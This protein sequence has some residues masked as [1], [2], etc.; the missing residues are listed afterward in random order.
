MKSNFEFKFGTIGESGVGKTSILR[1]LTEGRAALITESTLGVEHF[2]HAVQIENRLV[3]L[4]IWDTAGQ[5]RYGSIVK[6]YLRD[7]LGI[8]LVFDITDRSSF[9]LLPARYRSIA[10]EAAPN[11]SAVLVGNKTD[12]ADVRV[13]SQ[14]EAETFAKEHQIKYIETS[15]RNGEQ[16]QELFLQLTL[17]LLHKA[18]QGQVQ[19]KVFSEPARA[20]GFGCC[21]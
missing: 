18:E 20:R 5:E 9:E 15:A 10:E 8:L 17:D 11:F 4:T 14:S 7:A 3:R 1:Y 21:S 2:T 16:I 19:V 13:V 12:L 6:A